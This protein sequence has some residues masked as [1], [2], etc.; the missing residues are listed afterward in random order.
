MRCLYSVITVARQGQRDRLAEERA[1][2]E[3]LQAL[4][5]AREQERLR[6]SDSEITSMTAPEHRSTWRVGLGQRI[7]QRLGRCG[8]GRVCGGATQVRVSGS[9]LGRSWRGPERRR[10][11]GGGARW[12]L[13]DV[14]HS[15]V[16]HEKN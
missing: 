12:L 5:L 8:A 15:I 14:D 11:S 10:R 3:E 1:Y 7:Q 2:E 6:R 4:T 16:S 13:P 9:E